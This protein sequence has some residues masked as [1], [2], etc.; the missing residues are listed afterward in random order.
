MGG[1]GGRGEAARPS[2]PPGRFLWLAGRGRTFVRE[3]EGPPGAPAVVLLHGWTATADLNW[4]ACFA[5]LAEQLIAVAY[6][7]GGPVAQ[8]LWRRHRLLVDGLVLCATSRTFSGTARERVLTGVASGTSLLACA[9]SLPRM[10]GAAFSGWNGWRQRRGSPW[11]GFD[12]VARHDWGEI[13]EAGR[14]R[15]RFDSR[16]WTGEIACPSAVVVTDDD[17]VVPTRRQV[18]LAESLADHTTHHVSGGHAVCTTS[19]ERFVPALV[20][21]CTGAAARAAARGRAVAA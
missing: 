4:H 17:D 19:P 2:L 3:L 11:W 12:D 7:M 10:A 16:R 5:P 1:N 15:L 21:A 14:A 8:L 18:A 6:S 9:L 13:L 20:D